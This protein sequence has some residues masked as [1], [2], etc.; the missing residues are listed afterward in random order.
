M[1]VPDEVLQH[2]A[3]GYE[4]AGH[5]GKHLPGSEA[6]RYSTVARLLHQLAVELVT[7]W[8][9]IDAGLQHTL[10]DGYR[11]VRGVQ[12]QQAVE[13]PHGLVTQTR[14]PVLAV[15][16]MAI[17]IK[18]QSSNG[19]RCSIQNGRTQVSTMFALFIL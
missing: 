6:V 19:L 5:A 2:E 3:A 8:W 14:V 13:E 12:L 4:A 11:V 18:K 16:C 15:Y 1:Q 9:Q 7:Q 10:H 17:K